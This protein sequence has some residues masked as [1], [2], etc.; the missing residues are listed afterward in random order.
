MRKCRL[1]T[2]NSVRGWLIPLLI[3]IAG[4]SGCEKAR[5][6]DEVRRLC[7]IDGGVRVYE[8]VVLPAEKFDKYGL[9]L[10]P[11]KDKATL[12][13]DY[14]SERLITFY[15][16]GNPELWRT[17]FRIMRRSDGKVL[18]ESISYTR[19]GGDLPG[20][21]QASSFICPNPETRLSLEQSVF[22]KNLR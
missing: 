9:V 8:T 3:V 6:D 19:R 14:F 20:P 15:I 7:A 10:I 2:K 1:G 16:K 21:W 22:K 5:L 4:T 13:D 17:H 11:S 18:G 12:N